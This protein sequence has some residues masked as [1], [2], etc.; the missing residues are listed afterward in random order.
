[1]KKNS[2]SLSR[3]SS[4]R[5]VKT[6]FSLCAALCISLL[7]WAQTPTSTVQLPDSNH[8]LTFYANQTN[9]NLTKTFQAAIE[10]AQDSILMI[11]YSISDHTIIDC[12]NKQAESG[13]PVKLI[14]DAKTSPRLEQ[15]LSPHVHLVKKY[16]KGLMHQKILIV[17]HRNVWLG[18]ANMTSDSLKMHGNL[19]QGIN[20]QELAAFLEKKAAVHEGQAGRLPFQDTFTVGNQ[21]VEIWWLPCDQTAVQ[22]LQKLID[23]AKKTVR[24]AM[25]T[26]TRYDLARSII[27]A[28]RRQVDTEVVIDY[29]A[30]RGA[31]AKIVALLKEYNIKVFLSRPGPLLHHKFLYI[32]GEILV[33][34]SANWTKAAFTQNDD[35]FIVIEGLTESQKLQM[36]ELWET[37]RSDAQPP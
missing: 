31:G 17:D 9:D 33:N 18:S 19:V 30:G 29:Q 28:A 32:D 3:F 15:R 11:T 2:R 26:W 14:C 35:C 13:I 37:I 27:E 36:D 7:L 1:M 8:A 10:S 6:F 20:S 23:S 16:E 12:L 4:N 22:R 5:L 34:G 21:A 24:V 25:F